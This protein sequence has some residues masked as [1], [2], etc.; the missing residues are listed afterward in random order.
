MV[1]AEQ[2]FHCISEERVERIE[3]GRS[4]NPRG[5]AT[6]VAISDDGGVPAAIPSQQSVIPSRAGIPMFWIWYADKQRPEI[7]ADDND[8]TRRR[9]NQHGVQIDVVGSQSLARL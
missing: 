1:Y 3:G 4:L 9:E 8:K 2:R 5:V 6:L 7:D